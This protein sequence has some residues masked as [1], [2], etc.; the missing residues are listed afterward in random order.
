MSPPTRPPVSPKMTNSSY[1][2][3]G[4]KAFLVYSSWTKLTSWMI[5]RGKFIFSQRIGL[6]VMC[7]AIESV[8]LIFM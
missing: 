5:V 1:A 2:S 3:T 6:R 4:M 8:I 7:K